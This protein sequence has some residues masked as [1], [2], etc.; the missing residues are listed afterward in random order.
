MRRRLVL[1]DIDGTLLHSNGLGRRA[2][3]RA[4]AEHLAD[5]GVVDRIRFDGK[6]DPGIVVEV[7]TAA[8][9]PDPDEPGRIDRILEVYVDHLEEEIAG[10]SPGP[11]PRLLP[12][13]LALL[14]RLAVE[15]RVLPGLL[16][17]NVAPGAERKL[18]AVGL[19]PT[20]FA[21]GAYGSDHARRDALPAIAAS[22]AEPLL[23]HRPQGADLVIIGDTPAD[24][25]CGES[26][27]AR[28]IGV[29]T[30]S[31][32]ASALEAAGAYRV[33]STLEDG[34]MVCEAILC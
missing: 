18:R 34:D 8:G 7:L 4:L 24:V 1:F 30:G 3:G 21:V 17:G 22:R 13:V 28:A 32:E 16:T 6:T 27:G 20:R 19:A 11:E 9:I 26:L 33:F 15:P 14:D 12:G 10:R 23:G 31:Y 2:L 5:P 29:A 25:T